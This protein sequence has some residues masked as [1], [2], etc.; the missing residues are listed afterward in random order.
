VEFEAD[1]K[2]LNA[3]KPVAPALNSFFAKRPKLRNAVHK[4]VPAAVQ[5][6]I[7]DAMPYFAKT[8]KRAP[9]IDAEM[10]GKLIPVFKEDVE[11]TSELVGRDLTYWVKV[12]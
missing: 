10:R 5:R 9:K 2:V 4:L 12:E 3:V 8:I 7:A 1:F 6:K 11:R